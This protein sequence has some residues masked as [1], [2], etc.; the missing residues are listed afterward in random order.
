VEEACANNDMRIFAPENLNLFEGF[1]EKV[2]LANEEDDAT[3]IKIKIFQTGNE[4]FNINFHRQILRQFVP[5]ELTS[6]P[7]PLNLHLQ[8][9]GFPGD[10]ER[11]LQPTISENCWV[12]PAPLY[13]SKSKMKSKHALKKIKKNRKRSKKTNKENFLNYLQVNI[14]VR[15]MEETAVVH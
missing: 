5:L 13:H 15:F 8:M 3:I 14:I 1:C 4:E 11:N 9:F 7:A 10:P 6:F 2:V 12:L